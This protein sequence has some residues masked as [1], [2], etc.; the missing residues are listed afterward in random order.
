MEARCSTRQAIVVYRSHIEDADVVCS[1]ILYFILINKKVTC[2]KF[3]QNLLFNR[4]NGERH[5]DI[6]K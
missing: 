5:C 4:G 1:M 3:N 6:A 2:F